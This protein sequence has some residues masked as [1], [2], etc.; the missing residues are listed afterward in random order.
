MTNTKDG[1]AESLSRVCVLCGVVVLSLWFDSG[2]SF[3][4]VSMIDARAAAD[5]LTLK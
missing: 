1:E 5:A 2:G 4:T 3:S